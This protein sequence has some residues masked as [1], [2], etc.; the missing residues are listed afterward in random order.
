M[1]FSFETPYL[2][3]QSLMLCS[4]H[5]IYE[6]HANVFGAVVFKPALQIRSVVCHH[7]NA[8][9]ASGRVL[10]ATDSSSM[11]I[12]VIT[13]C[14][15]Q[16]GAGAVGSCPCPAD[17]AAARRGTDTPGAPTGP[18]GPQ[19]RDEALFI[20]RCRVTIW[21][22][23]N[24]ASEPGRRRALPAAAEGA[25][26]VHRSEV[27]SVRSPPPLTELGTCTG[28]RSGARAAR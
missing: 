22:R 20:D 6:I 4:V 9:F 14:G 1:H 19:G 8:K 18:A 26:H 17:C 24:R 7:P 5:Y 10:M 21:Q 27:R 13:K 11:A 2:F 16:P 25:G 12:Q 28:Q 23:V 3:Q 15:P